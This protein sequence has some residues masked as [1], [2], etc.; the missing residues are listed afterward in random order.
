MSP[1]PPDRNDL[2][3]RDVPFAE[4][5]ALDPD[6]AQM[7]RSY[8]RE[9]AAAR[10]AAA[11]WEY[12]AS[13]AGNLFDNALM[14]AD[15]THKD[16]GPLEEGVLA[17]AIDPL[18][19]P[20]LLTVGSIEYQLGREDAAMEL[21][22]TLTTLPDDEPELV[23]IV[24]KATGFLADAGDY[25]NTLRLYEAAAA[26]SPHAATYWSG[27]GYGL[28]KLGRFE[29]AIAAN[30]CAVELEPTNATWRS[31]L[32][33]SLAEDGQLAEARSLLLQAIEMSPDG[34][35]LARNNLEWVEQRIRDE[36]AEASR[37]A[38]PK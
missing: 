2:T 9:T 29:E 33:W 31:D 14:L 36:A 20:A 38:D 22:L 1:E 23:E 12:E 27:C 13:I 4:L 10:R 18:F 34:H 7:R 35:E 6:L 30:R 8:A 15:P 24:E 17:L 26:A 32:A 3:L 21:F 19:A 11:E 28:G 16:P 25:E 5:V 37:A